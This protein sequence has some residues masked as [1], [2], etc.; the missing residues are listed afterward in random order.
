MAEDRRFRSEPS[1]GSRVRSRRTAAGRVSPGWLE[2]SALARRGV[3]ARRRGPAAWPELFDR[4]GWAGSGRGELSGNGLQRPLVPA[5]VCFFAGL[6][7]GVV[8]R[9]YPMGGA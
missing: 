6:S 1:D 4:A 8:S 7:R 5:V 3:D 2:A 9:T